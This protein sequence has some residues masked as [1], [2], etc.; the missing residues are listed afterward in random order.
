M[1][2]ITE[3]FSERTIS[4][5]DMALESACRILPETL[6]HH[7]ARTYVAERIVEC[8]RS[9]TQSLDALTEAGKRAVAELAMLERGVTLDDEPGLSA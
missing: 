5:M 9:H 6:A 4:R 2:L 8:A 7:G 3:Q 1:M